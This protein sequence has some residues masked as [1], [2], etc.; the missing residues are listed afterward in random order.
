M[1]TLTPGWKHEA[2]EQEEWCWAEREAGPPPAGHTDGEDGERPG[3][4]ERRPAEAGVD[5]SDGCL[6]RLS[7]MVPVA[8]VTHVQ[9]DS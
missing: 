3:Q 8:Y 4:R 2:M 5:S 9:S 6:R 7:S 1:M